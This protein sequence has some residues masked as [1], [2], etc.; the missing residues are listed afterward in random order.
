MKEFKFYYLR[1]KFLSNVYSDKELFENKYSKRPFVGYNAGKYLIL[2]PQT[3]IKKETLSK[4]SNLHYYEH[5]YECDNIHRIN[6]TGIIICPDNK[7]YATEIYA[8]A[9]MK[10]KLNEISKFSTKQ[11][12]NQFNIDKKIAKILTL[13]RHHD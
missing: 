7:Q 4:H 3:T 9:F 8:D 1:G 12:K 5:I 6:L 11:V 2:F 13:S 10:S